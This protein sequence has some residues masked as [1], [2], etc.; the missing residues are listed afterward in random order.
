[1]IGNKYFDSRDAQ[2]QIDDLLAKINDLDD[3]EAGELEALQALKDDVFEPSWDQG[4]TFIRD[5]YFPEYAEESSY[6]VGDLQRG[7][8]LA[9]LIDWDRVADAM[10]QDFKQVG[11]G[12]YTYWYRS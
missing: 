9:G 12:G 2:K 7:S 6:D 5:D 8:F 4:V 1:M 3:D 11:V 10:Q